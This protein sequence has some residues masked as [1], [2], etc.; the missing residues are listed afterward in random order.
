MPS[1]TVLSYVHYY[2][3]R[4]A[5][6]PSKSTILEGTPNRAASALWPVLKDQD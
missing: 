2:Y 5:K 3:D 4:G 6:S 1:G